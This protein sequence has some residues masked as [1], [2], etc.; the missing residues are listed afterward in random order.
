MQATLFAIDEIVRAGGRKIVL[1]PSRM[2]RLFATAVLTAGLADFFNPE[3][4]TT[5]TGARVAVDIAAPG[6]Q[7]PPPP[8]WD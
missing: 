1:F 3:T 4:N 8:I 6:E 2:R 5:I 7:C